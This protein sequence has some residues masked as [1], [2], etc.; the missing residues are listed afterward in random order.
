MNSSSRIAR[1]NPERT[2]CSSPAP[3]SVATA[4]MVTRAIASGM[5][6][7]PATAANAIEY[8]AIWASTDTR[9]STSSSERVQ[10]T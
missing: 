7:S 1:Q 4:G 2:R 6:A 10:M 8:S 3:I 9:S 5:R